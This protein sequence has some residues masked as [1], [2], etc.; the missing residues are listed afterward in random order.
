MQGIFQ[1]R[2]AILL[3]MSW[4][5][6]EWNFFWKWVKPK[7]FEVE[8]LMIKLLNFLQ[9]PA[10]FKYYKKLSQNLMPFVTFLGF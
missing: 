8:C 1:L 7:F 5:L 3:L 2:S 9:D 10:L 4:F 6:H